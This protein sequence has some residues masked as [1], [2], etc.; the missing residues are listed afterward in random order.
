MHAETGLMQMTRAW[1]AL[2]VAL[3]FASSGP[4]GAAD[5]G[6]AL[7]AKVDQAISSAAS[8]RVAV[9]GPSG[10]ALDI[11]SVRPDRIRVRSTNGVNSYVSIV[12]G[13]AMYYS[14]TPNGWTAQGVPVVKRARKNLLYMGAPDAALEPLAD[15][16]EAGVTYGRF[17]SLAVANSQLPATMECTY[18][19]RTYRPYACTVVLQGLTTPIHVTYDKWDDPSNVVEPPPGVPV[20][21]PPPELPPSPQPGV[22]Q[23]G[24]GPLGPIPPPPTAPGPLPTR[25]PI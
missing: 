16:T 22:P 2:T 23:P 19:K 9:T 3:V 15:R 13:S 5:D 24:P 7:S 14:S 20:P 6:A 17:G 8:Y 1:S 21:T 18:D 11:V 25:P 10:L 4:A 12:V